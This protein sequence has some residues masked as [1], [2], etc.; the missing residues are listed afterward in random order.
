VESPSYDAL[1]VVVGS[2][3]LGD[4]ALAA[5]PVREAAARTE[6]PVVVF[7]SPHALNIVAHLNGVGVPAFHTPEGCAAALVAMRTRSV[8][9][10]VSAEP[11]ARTQPVAGELPTGTLNEAESLALF[12][13]Y[14]IEPVRYAVA[15][16]PEEAEAYASMFGA[17]VVVKVLSRE[18]AHKSEVGGVRLGVAP[19]DVARVCNELGPGDGWMVQEQIDASQATEMLL[20]V[21][22]D[23]QLGLAIVLGAGGTAAEVFGDTA[24]R[25]LPLD[26][27]DAESMLTEL[28]SRA[29]LDGFRGRAPGDVP[30]LLE[31]VRAMSRMALAL[32]DRLVEAEINPLFVLPEGRGVRAA[33]GLV[34]LGS[35][36]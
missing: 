2:S 23:P 16:T 7:V 18:I 14:G 25:L 36:A 29:L 31:A 20:G 5:D 33:D 11:V 6:K 13:A 10:S 8:R 9:R 19:E 22:R 27:S 30:A 28:K 17:R 35:G 34:V 1:V 15:H 3:G 24:L 12:A 32:G 21:I 26:V 4:P